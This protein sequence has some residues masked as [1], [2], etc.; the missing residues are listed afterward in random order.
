MDKKK[1]KRNFLILEGVTSA[2]LKFKNSS[3]VSVPFLTE[4][5]RGDC[6]IMQY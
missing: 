5:L 2:N 6:V 4:G 1:K 3:S